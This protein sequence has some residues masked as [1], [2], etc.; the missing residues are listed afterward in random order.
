ME[1]RNV[2]CWRTNN[3]SD[4]LWQ[5]HLIIISLSYN[6]L[7]QY[8]SVTLY[9]INSQRNVLQITLF[10]LLCP[11]PRSSWA[12][13]INCWACLLVSFSQSGHYGE[14]ARGS[15]FAYGFPPK[16]IWGQHTIWAAAN[17]HGETHARRTEGRFRKTLTT[18]SLIITTYKLKNQIP[19]NLPTLTKSKQHTNTSY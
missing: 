9:V 19:L 18:T 5:I 15:S 10:H 12:V 11:F 3:L 16:T 1:K 8:L 6:S 17:T 2:P 4:H 14:A 7:C 13:E